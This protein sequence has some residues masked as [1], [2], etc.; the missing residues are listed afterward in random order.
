VRRPK[1]DARALDEDY[2]VP[3]LSTV[4]GVAIVIYFGD[5]LPPHFHAR[6]QGQG[7]QVAIGPPVR[8]LANSLPPAQLG[9]V[10]EWAEEHWLE[11]RR[12]WA[13]AYIHE[14]PSRIP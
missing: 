13:R 3:R 9:L 5:H 11:L 10:L 6:Y 12:A 14:G 2:R 8:V 1:G 7:A 4:G